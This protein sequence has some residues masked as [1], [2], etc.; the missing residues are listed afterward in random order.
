MTEEQ[1]AL[2][3]L[4]RGLP[5]AEVVAIMSVDV[6]E[7][8]ELWAE[9]DSARASKME[10]VI[11]DA[12]WI[13]QQQLQSPTAEAQE[14][15]PDDPESEEIEPPPADPTPEPPDDAGMAVFDRWFP[16]LNTSRCFQLP[17]Q[18]EIKGSNEAPATYTIAHGADGFPKCKKRGPGHYGALFTRSIPGMYVFNSPTT[19]ITI[20]NLANGQVCALEMDAEGN[21]SNKS[22]VIPDFP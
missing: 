22:Q 21:V 15:P 14:P 6:A 13:R 8:E 2:A 7:I 20:T 9:L 1:I 12:L 4:M 16:A 5:T 10:R 18:I 19:R 17:I 11:S 3:T